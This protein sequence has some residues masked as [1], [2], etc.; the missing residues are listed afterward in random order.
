[1][2]QQHIASINQVEDPRPAEAP[3]FSAKYHVAGMSCGH[4]QNAVIQEIGALD[5]VVNVKV[6][7]STGQVVVAS[8]RPI[9]RSAIENAV[10]E[11]GY[12]LV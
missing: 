5:G 6:H 9:P 2:N 11:A 8:R 3:S 4:C 10:D 7:L 12:A 1:M